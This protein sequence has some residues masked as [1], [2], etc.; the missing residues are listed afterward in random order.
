MENFSCTQTHASS[1]NDDEQFLCRTWFRSPY[2]IRIE[3]FFSSETIGRE[4]TTQMLLNRNLFP[5]LL[6]CWFELFPFATVFPSFYLS[7]SQSVFARTSWHTH[8]HRHTS[9]AERKGNKCARNVRGAT[10]VLRA[11]G[12]TDNKKLNAPKSH[13]H[14]NIL[15]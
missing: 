13:K 15:L 3:F 8:T 10:H 14:Y 2:N 6:C 11:N 1:T 4:Y 9:E 7:T 12:P 5:R